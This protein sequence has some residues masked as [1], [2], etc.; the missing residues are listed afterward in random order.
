MRKK[1]SE[2][3]ITASS[4]SFYIDKSKNIYLFMSLSLDK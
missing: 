4:L 1:E 3:G 2:R